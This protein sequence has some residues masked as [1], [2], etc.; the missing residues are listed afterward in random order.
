MKGLTFKQQ[1]ICDLVVKGLSSKEIARIVGVGHRTVEST[2]Y[3]IYKKMGVKNAFQ[4][5]A[6]VL[7]PAQ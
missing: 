3:D 7:A 2:R 5:I 6:K 1:R 4:L